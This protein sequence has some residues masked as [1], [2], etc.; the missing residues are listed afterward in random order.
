MATLL[1]KGVF[2]K[3]HKDCG[4]LIE[5]SLAELKED[6]STDY[7]GDRDYYR[8]LICPGCGEKMCFPQYGSVV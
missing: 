7:L 5:F 1:K 6:Y 4:S 2:Q 8:Y 3:T